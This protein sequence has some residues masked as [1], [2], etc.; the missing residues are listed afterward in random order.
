MSCAHP[1]LG[2]HFGVHAVQIVTLALVCVLVFLGH[3]VPVR[4]ADGGASMALVTGLIVDAGEV[5]PLE[6]GVFVELVG[7]YAVSIDGR[8]DV[9]PLAIADRTD[10]PM[11]WD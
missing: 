4:S 10:F 11:R 8:V 2:C 6:V 5:I 7:S 3:C 1:P 9:G